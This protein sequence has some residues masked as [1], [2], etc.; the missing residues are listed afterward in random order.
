MGGEFY[1]DTQ[2]DG[3]HIT[4]TNSNVDHSTAKLIAIALNYSLTA[5]PKLLSL[6]LLLMSL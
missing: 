4:I 6:L 3:F 5:L 1:F 2:V